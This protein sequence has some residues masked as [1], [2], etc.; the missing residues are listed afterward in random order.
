MP[1]FRTRFRSPSDAPLTPVTAESPEAAAQVV[2]RRINRR[3][4]A[5]RCTGTPGMSG[6]FQ[7]YRPA[8]QGG[9]ESINRSLH[10][11]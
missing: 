8:Q 6:V 5:R 4:L 1:I 3:Y 7:I 10:V 2:A 9:L 11:W